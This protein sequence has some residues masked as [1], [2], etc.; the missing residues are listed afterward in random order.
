MNSILYLSVDLRGV[1]HVV[2]PRK[3]LGKRNAFQLEILCSPDVSVPVN[4]SSFPGEMAELVFKSSHFNEAQIHLDQ[5]L[6]LI[7]L[8]SGILMGCAV[9]G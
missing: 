6:L 9:C 4:G 5:C 8:L 1:L 7:C 3:Y 2:C